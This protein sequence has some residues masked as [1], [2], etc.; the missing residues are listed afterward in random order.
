[1]NVASILSSLTTLSIPALGFNWI[2]ILV[3]VIVIFYTIQG[4]SLGFL[5]AAVD[6]VSF[7][8][9]F[10][11]G[12]SLYGF[13]AK[14]LVQFFSI[15]QGFAN[16]I[17]FFVVAVLFEIVFTLLIRI[18]LTKL[19]LFHIQET[20]LII[21]KTIGKFLGIIPG[22]LSG[23]L[24]SSFILSLIIALPFSVFLKHSVINSKIGG[25]L[26]ANTQGFTKS[27]QTIFG[28]ALNDTL[29][30]LTVEPK[31][32]ELVSLNFKTG[33]ISIDKNAEQQMFADVNHERTSRNIPALTLSDPLTAVA[34]AHCADMFKRG[35]FSHYT[36]EGLS[37]FDRMTQADII[38]NYAGE[39]LALAPSEDLAMKGLMQSEGH[40][41]NILST[42]FRQIG[43][44]VIDGGVYGEMFCQE[45][46]D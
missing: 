15:P 7:A 24:L 42:N 33:N 28:G 34:R 18:F 16:A 26:V 44:G 4:F 29:S 38:F 6:F 31:S 19:P 45:F 35:Y 20:N 5:T 37:P 41:E 1:M 12:L 11:L 32:N 46:S 9:S 23:L 14:L 3:L 36:P 39:N 43:V 27:W 21:T 8:I 13:V 10:L 25:V 2:D 40:K 30:F 17:G 22:I